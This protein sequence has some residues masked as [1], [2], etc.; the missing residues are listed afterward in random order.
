MSDSTAISRQTISLLMLD[1]FSQRSK[2]R[3]E[4]A[5]LI[6]LGD[7][8]C[9]SFLEV[10]ALQI[11]QMVNRKTTINSLRINNLFM[12]FMYKVSNK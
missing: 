10:T 12:T 9:E 7:K 4:Q 5:H 3:L 6:K 11:S 1:Q 2:M 8:P